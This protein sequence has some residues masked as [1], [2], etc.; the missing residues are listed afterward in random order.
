MKLE[1]YDFTRF[2]RTKSSE[3]VFD[4][5]VLSESV[6]KKDWET[7]EGDEAWSNL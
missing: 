7:P 6:L 1:V 2:L 5:L 3:E 4:G